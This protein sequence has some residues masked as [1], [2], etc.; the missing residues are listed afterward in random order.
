MCYNKDTNKGLWH[1]RE[2]VINPCE[3]AGQAFTDFVTCELGFLE[4]LE[5][6]FFFLA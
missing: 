4:L 5:A 2:A 3:E 6:I 1:Q